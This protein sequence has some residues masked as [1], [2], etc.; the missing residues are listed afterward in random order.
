MPYVG[1]LLYWMCSYACQTEPLKWSVWRMFCHLLILQISF[2]II[3][4]VCWQQHNTYLWE[5]IVFI[6]SSSVILFSVASSDINS[7]SF[8]TSRYTKSFKEKDD[9]PAACS[10][11]SLRRS[12]DRR[13]YSSV[14]IKF[15]HQF[16]S[17]TESLELNCCNPVLKSSMLG[18]LLYTGRNMDGDPVGTTSRVRIM[19]SGLDGSHSF[20]LHLDQL[21]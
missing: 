9:F 5:S 20:R 1:L 4:E 16:D 3:D 18:H 14:L 15:S 11:S 10:S 2:Q 12:Q 8:L 6:L 17:S 21:R 19:S 13:C 7:M